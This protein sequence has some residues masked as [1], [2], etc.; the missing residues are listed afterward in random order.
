MAN[1][2]GLHPWLTVSSSGCGEEAESSY[3][4]YSST[5]AGFGRGNARFE[6]GLI[7]LGEKIVIIFHGKT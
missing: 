6:C 3:I 1:H 2:G 7:N 4:G 5:S